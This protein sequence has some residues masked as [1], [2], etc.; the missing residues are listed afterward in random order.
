MWRFL[1]LHLTTL[2]WGSPYTRPI[3]FW[4]LVL[5]LLLSTCAIG[6]L[7]I[8][9]RKERAM[10][11]EDEEPTATP[12]IMSPTTPIPSRPM[13]KARDI[14]Q[15]TRFLG[16]ALL[17]C[18]V[19][20]LWRDHQLGAPVQKP[21]YWDVLVVER[22]DNQHFLLNAPGIGTWNAT[23]CEP[24]D[25]QRHEK[26]KY[27]SFRQHLGCKDVTRQGYYA[28][29]TDQRGNRIKFYEEVANAKY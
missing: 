7:V 17:G 6:L 18:V 1:A 23:T 29:W 12:E 27:L 9:L 28:F 2:G 20:W 11:M 3:F 22:R 25:W 15:A 4:L 24:V 5:V 16:V 8:A 19:G 26:M 14:K 10:V 21:P 13:S